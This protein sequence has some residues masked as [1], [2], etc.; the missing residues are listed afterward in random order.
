MNSPRQ[1]SRITLTDVA[2]EAGVSVQTASHV[3]AENLTVRL[4]EATRQRVKAAAAKVGYR[5]NRL[6]QAMKKGKT[7]VVGVWMPLDRPVVSY[8]RFL[9]AINSLARK[10]DFE[11]MITGLDAS[12]AY[13]A[14]GRL[15]HLWPVDGII[16]LD[17]GKAMTAFREDPRNLS[18]P[19]AVLGNEKFE[20]SD[21]VSWDLVGGSKA[22]T[23]RAIQLGC[24]DIV[25]VSLDWVLRD[26]PDENRRCGYEQAMLDAGLEPKFISVPAE[27]ST[28]AA[29]SVGEYLTA[30]PTPDAVFGF[31]DTI[32]IG[33]A[34]A[35]LAAGR[36]IPKE[37]RIWGYGDFPESAD[38]RIPISTMR[39]PI[40]EVT[41]QAW[42]WLMERFEN[43]E[44]KSRAAEIPLE[45][46]ERESTLPV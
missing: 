20:N 31:T 29:Q 35:I 30:N 34:R 4:P 33:A 44:Q 27:S 16:A 43:P 6:A 36:Q 25:H 13:A 40:E 17:A 42:D 18:T 21:S 12:M 24:R 37:C 2:R 14:E 15:P 7:N 10:S 8:L 23:N 5:P 38:Y 11:L 9:Q 41:K 46:I 32:A 3:L 39:I 22:A 28:A 19:I 1:H 45:F 26:F